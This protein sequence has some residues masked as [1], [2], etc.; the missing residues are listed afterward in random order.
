MAVF[1]FSCSSLACSFDG[2]ASTDDNG[3][4]SYAWNFGD[5]TTGSGATASRTYAAAGTYTVTLTV[6][7]TGGQT[8]STA[9]AVAVTSGG[10]GGISLT[11]TGYKVKGNQT[12]DLSWSGASA[13]SVDVYRNGT[14]ITT[15]AND[16]AHTDAINQKGGG[17]YVYRVCNAGTTTC[18]SNVTVTF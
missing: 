12:V 2:G 8:G 10:G 9:S 18:S 7:D 14:L 4:T 17:S 11:A 3:I 13:A 15:T 5:G 16:G 6:T 1:T